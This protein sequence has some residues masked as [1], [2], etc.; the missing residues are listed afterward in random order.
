LQPLGVGGD[1]Q[2]QLRLTLDYGNE[3]IRRIHESSHVRKIGV[4]VVVGRQ[5]M[6]HVQGPAPRA[7]GFKGQL[8]Q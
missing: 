5:W 6:G 7:E 3:D 2:P 8:M 1:E 4:V